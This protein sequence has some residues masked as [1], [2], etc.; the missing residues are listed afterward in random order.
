MPR[1]RA[2]QQA[3]IFM[4]STYKLLLS[5]LLLF[6]L[7]LFVDQKPAPKL[8]LLTLKSNSTAEGFTVAERNVEIGCIKSNLQTKKVR[9]RAG[10]VKQFMIEYT[11][12]FRTSFYVKCI[13]LKCRSSCSC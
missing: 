13:R 2:R 6:T 5:L 9:M 4:N 11:I 12:K 10:R 1:S 3:A 7:F 8:V